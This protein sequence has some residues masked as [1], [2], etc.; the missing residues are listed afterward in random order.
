M[1]YNL[2][3]NG[4]LTANTASG[5][6]GLTSLTWTQLESLMDQVLDTGGVT[7]S[8]SD[9]LYLDGD[10]TQR[11]KVD[12]INL[13][14]TGADASNVSFYYKDEPTDSYTLRPTLSGVGYLYTTIPDP[15]APRYIRC[16]I[17]GVTAQI[18]EFQVFNDDYIVAFGTDGQLLT[19]YLGETPQGQ[20]SGV[21]AIPIYNDGTSATS[22]DAYVCV[23][24]QG[25]VQDGYLEI[26]ASENGPFYSFDD[27]GFVEDDDSDSTWKWSDGELTHL[28][29]SNDSLII[30][31]E[32]ESLIFNELSSVP[33]TI[34]NY[35]LNVG[36]SGWDID[37]VSG[38]MYIMTKDSSVLTLWNYDYINNTWT[39][40]TTLDPILHQ[41]E[42]TFPGMVY[43]K[44]FSSRRI[45]AYLTRAGDVFGYHDLDGAA[46]NWTLTT[47][48]PMPSWIT[49]NIVSVITMCSDNERY[50]YLMAAT[51]NNGGKLFLRFDTETTTWSGMS[52]GY[53]L[54][55]TNRQGTLDQADI[56]LAYDY[57]R[58][59]I[60]TMASHYADKADF[61]RYI[62]LYDVAGDFWTNEYIY[63]GDIAHTTNYPRT[64]LHYFNNYLYMGPDNSATDFNVYR[65]AV[66]S[67]ERE[68]I[69][70]VSYEYP[71]TSR[72][73]FGIC[74]YFMALALP[75]GRLGLFM[76]NITTD[77][78]KIYGSLAYDLAGTYLSPIFKI[79]SDMNSSFWI[80]DG[81]TESGTSSI[82]YDDNLYNGT[83]RV[84]SSATVPLT[85]DNV[86]LPFG[87]P[88]ALA[89]TEWVPYT[90]SVDSGFISL[91]TIYGRVSMSCLAS[92]VDRRTGDIIVAMYDSNFFRQDAY[93]EKYPKDGGTYTYTRTWGANVY[94]FGYNMV[95]DKNGGVWGYS[96]LYHL[97]HFDTDLN[98]E[99]A[100]IYD[101]ADFLNSLAEEMDG[102]GAWYTSNYGALV[103]IDY[104]GSTLKT[105]P[106][107]DPQGIC[108]TLD[109]GCWVVE[110]TDD[111]VIRYDS[112]GILVTFIDIG[113]DANFICHDF[114]NGFWYKYLD[115]V[116]HVNSNGVRNV[117][118]VTIYQAETL[119]PS[120]NGVYVLSTTANKVSFINNAGTVTKE[121]SHTLTN[122]VK[123]FSVFSYD[124]DDYV[125][126]KTHDILPVSYD[127][128]WG[129]G[130]TSELTEV[131]KDGYFLPKVLYHQMEATLRG[132]GGSID[133]LIMAP[134][135]NI[136]D[137]N[138]QTSKN[139]YVKAVIPLEA[140]IENYETKIRAWWGLEE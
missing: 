61:E 81:T 64:T 32:S 140:S 4:S 42:K 116:Y 72:G 75:N 131:V 105:I 107:S 8:G 5:T 103:H 92:A 63:W 67:L 58:D 136:P 129:T 83:I 86:Y 35:G 1:Q 137:I 115:D 118:P 126:F 97:F 56:H 139:V 29:I 44:S 49:D 9:V 38:E 23:E 91:Q 62:E 130:G 73:A 111:K 34:D 13:Y 30:D 98:Y 122:D 77:P 71:Q 36:M 76:Q 27:G 65:W 60:Y 21:N 19:E 78:S 46:E 96:T 39:Y 113:H 125:E 31:T 2:F 68:A 43:C 94:N 59:V 37:R 133:K 123:Y 53:T 84:R 24:P 54:R 7:V 11:I 15:S 40:K 138:R 25:Q 90:N 87:G 14:H 104:L 89:I 52:D 33:I 3:R 80:T 6:G 127:P 124:H 135:V 128:V 17:S 47:S 106:L 20:E 95:I 41:S 48:Y 121:W 117:G 26:A 134:A 28:L 10:L 12:G 119:R 85:V 22:A 93:L 120:H 69:P 101:G 114:E 79:T 51:Y 112:S 110:W 57:D 45:Y 99:Y 66:P 108:G 16:T 74:Y 50:I 82:S 100:D 132:V 18:H 102:D 109:N 55:G 88:S 70:T